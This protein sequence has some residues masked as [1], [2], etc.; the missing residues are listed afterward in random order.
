MKRLLT[1]VGLGVGVTLLGAGTAFA[2]CPQ[3]DY[4]TEEGWYAVDETFTIAAGDACDVAVEF[5][6]V[7]H[8]RDTINGQVVDLEEWYAENEPEVGDRHVGRAP[9]EQMTLTNLATKKSVHKDISGTFYDRVV[10]FGRDGV[11]DVRTRAVGAN[12]FFGPGI[13][14]IV[15]ADGVQKVN[16][17][18]FFGETGGEQDIVKTKGKTVELCKRVGARAVEGRAPA[19]TD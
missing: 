14:G 1:S 12:V 7:G 11:L 15:W 2:G 5:H 19:P 18:D 16:T 13:K 9:D 3:M 6:V 8:Q 17:Y 4:P 10:D